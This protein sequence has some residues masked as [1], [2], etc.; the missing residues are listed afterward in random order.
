MSIIDTQQQFA[1]LSQTVAVMAAHV[2][3]IAKTVEK[4]EE[5]NEGTTRTH[6]MKAKI[7]MA[8]AD[9]E[10]NK[11]AWEK[12]DGDIRALSAN[13]SMMIR[14]S[15]V[16]IQNNVNTRMDSLSTD[17]KGKIDGLSTDINTKIGSVITEAAT[18][19]GIIAKIQPWVNGISWVVLTA[20]G[21]I[22]GLILSGQWQIIS[23]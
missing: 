4:L 8:Q 18:Q 5:A 17:M 9:I 1:E 23:R 10:R 15:F 12:V 13:L 2:D 11:Q 16:E 3:N 14:D 19:K 7:A 22:L 21:I 6:G 20:G